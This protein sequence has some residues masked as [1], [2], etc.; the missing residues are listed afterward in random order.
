MTTLSIKFQSS[1]NK[2][3]YHFKDLPPEKKPSIYTLIQLLASA[4]KDLIFTFESPRLEIYDSNSKNL[5]TFVRTNSQIKKYLTTYVISPENY[6]AAINELNLSL[7]EKSA[8]ASPKDKEENVELDDDWE[9]IADTTNHLDLAEVPAKP[10]HIVPAST[11][12][13]LDTFRTG[14]QTELQQQRANFNKNLLNELTNHSNFTLT[15]QS[16]PSG[17]RLQSL[18]AKDPKKIIA[19]DS[20]TPHWSLSYFPSFEILKDSKLKL[21]MH[22]AGAKQTYTVNYDMNKPAYININ[23]Y[24]PLHVQN[25]LSHVFA[26]FR[27]FNKDVNAA[28]TDKQ[29]IN[30][31]ENYKKLA[32]YLIYDQFS[33]EI[34]KRVEELGYSWNLTSSAY[35]VIN[36]HFNLSVKIVPNTPGAHIDLDDMNYFINSQQ[37]LLKEAIEDNSYKTALFLKLSSSLLSYPDFPEVLLGIILA[38][39]DLSFP[40]P[41]PTTPFPPLI[42]T[43]ITLFQ[44]NLDIIPTNMNANDYV[45]NDASLPQILNTL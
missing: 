24:V 18:I 38:Y 5:L 34:I 39:C 17:I 44:R 30:P 11:A 32:S 27:E 31:K 43:D 26:Y 22:V 20:S 7:E 16:E 15:F 1:E 41:L 37:L 19:F 9:E 4:H 36:I 29:Y 35:S 45:E 12:S 6:A 40:K 23:T 8:P 42:E 14:W 33:Y 28:G 3:T 2:I 21:S 13:I 10:A 25:E